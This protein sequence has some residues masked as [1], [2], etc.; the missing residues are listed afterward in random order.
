MIDTDKL[1]KGDENTYREL[2]NMYFA[3]LCVFIRRNFPMDNQEAENIVQDVFLSIYSN[4]EVLVNI[5][6]IKSYLY[7]SVRNKCLNYLRNEK[8]RVAN[9]NT[10]YEKFGNEDFLF[11]KI[12]ENEVYR[13]LQKAMDDLP[14]QCKIIFEKVLNGD[15]SAKIARDM[16]LSIETIKTQRK[17]AKK[18]LKERFKLIYKI[19]QFVL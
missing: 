16:S 18:I 7:S 19:F 2:C 10:Y 11:N 12:V 4:R 15:S 13:E 1:I 6:S 5:K 9:D 8:R 3:P 14:P 17:K